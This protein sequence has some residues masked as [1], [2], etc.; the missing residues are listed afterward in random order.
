MCRPLAF[1]RVCVCVL[2]T[3]RRQKQA[4]PEASVR[5]SRN[6]L[7]YA[8]LLPVDAFGTGTDF[9]ADGRGEGALGGQQ[10][11]KERKGESEQS[12]RLI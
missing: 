11:E 12:W 3:T 1:V 8:N 5:T 10:R 9:Q 4:V 6:Q 7:W 2:R